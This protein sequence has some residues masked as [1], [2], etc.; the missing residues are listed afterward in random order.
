MQEKQR[1]LNQK[2][3]QSGLRNTSMGMQMAVKHVQVDL[4][5]FPAGQRKLFVD[6]QNKASYRNSRGYMRR[7][8]SQVNLFSSAGALDVKCAKEDFSLGPK[9]GLHNLKSQITK[10]N[11][12]F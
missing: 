3:F 9:R 10:S 5:E 11:P 2:T 1:I 7:S 6:E 4:S 12:V 8:L